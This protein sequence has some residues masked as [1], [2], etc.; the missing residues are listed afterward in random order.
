MNWSVNFKMSPATVLV[1]GTCDTKLRELLFLKSQIQNSA[2]IGTILMDVGKEDVQHDE[3]DISQAQLV[4]DHGH[5][6]TTSDLPRGEV[7][8]LMASCAAR[9]VKSLLEKGG[10]SGIIS[11]GVRYS[12]I[13][14]TEIHFG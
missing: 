6:Q 8:K 12:G 5:G 1:L 14:I 2:S 13:H 7:V 4:A 3:I 11:A 9:A 10:I